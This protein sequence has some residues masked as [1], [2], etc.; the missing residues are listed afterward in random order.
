V[1]IGSRGFAALLSVI[2]ITLS[3]CAAPSRALGEI[4]F[5]EVSSQ[6]GIH[7]KGATWGA[8][9]GDFDADGW[10]D[11][12]VGNHNRRPSLYLNQR[13]GTFVDV[14]EQVWSGNPR[15]DAH[16]AAWADF[17]GDG[18]QDL[19]ELVG[20][21]E[22]PDGT[23]RAAAGGN[24]LFVNTGSAL[25]DEAAERGL[26]G[27]GNA[28][29]PLWLD[30]D[31]DGDLDL[32]VTNVPDRDHGGSVLYLQNNGRFSAAPA[33]LG[34]RD[35]RADRWE[36]LGRL[37]DNL[38][39]WRWDS[40]VA[41][42]T[43][44]WLRS[45]QLA[46]ITGDRRL[47]LIL[48]SDPTRIFRIGT[49]GLEDISHALVSPAVDAISDA[50]FAD[51]NGD[52]RM[53][54]YFTRG[55]YLPP[56]VRQEGNRIYGTL[57]GVGRNREPQGVRFSCPGRVRFSI[58]P[59]WLPLHMVRI[60][61]SA[62]TPKTRTF[63]LDPQDGEISPVAETPPSLNNVVLIYWE[64]G[65]AQWY[66]I[67]RVRHRPMDFVIEC[68]TEVG[69]LSTL[70]FEPFH[71]R[72]RDVLLLGGDGGF[73]Q[74]DLGK[75]GEESACH[76]VVA[77]DF[78]ND[79]DE[80][81]YMV[82]TGPVKNL[83]NRLLE[84]DG[85][86]GFTVVPNAG[87]AAGSMLGRGDTVVVADYDRDGFLD[88]FV[89]NGTDPAG[90]FVEDGPHQLFRN[91]GNGNHWIEID[92]VGVPPN[93]DAIGAFVEVVAGGKRQ[94]RAQGG[95]MHRLSENHARVHFG[96]GANRRIDEIRIRWPDGRQQFLKNVQADQILTIEEPR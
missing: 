35:G 6:A 51:F 27:H 46:D 44:R 63:E 17:D 36:R 92:L 1:S 68:P 88:L 95:G 30:A 78:D 66:L 49:D 90:P 81:L 57:K 56:D 4:R 25:V 59:T 13:D 41:W 85:Q 60:G 21:L 61:E 69:D 89:T 91:V 15:D 3:W 37:V 28:V 8:S 33:D 64:P 67:N 43:V 26:T 54:V 73:R 2:A 70:N 34:F 76:F 45:A 50:A 42:R 7:H 75:A 84:N 38:L 16:G 55:E 77:A 24:H 39:H 53:D 29:S 9:W 22:M 19:V 23:L 18:D 11:L 74:A 31:L 82:C 47:E 14:A 79:M 87:G 93:R 62:L 10:P 72:G 20:A 94:I 58:Y 32:L 48:F 65:R 71:P 40:G 5:Q 86:G 52:G 83:P 80:D 12:W 96:L